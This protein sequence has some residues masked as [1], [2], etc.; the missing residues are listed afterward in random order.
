MTASS[1]DLDPRTRECLKMLGLE[2]DFTPDQLRRR[3][4]RG[5]RKLSPDKGG[6]P[7]LFNKLQ[8]AYTFLRV[9]AR[10]DEIDLN[11]PL[12][13]R[14]APTTLTAVPSQGRRYKTANDAYAA[15]YGSDGC[16]LRGHGDWLK[17]DVP[18][19]Q[20]PPDRVSESRLN[21][22]FEVLN[23]SLGRGPQA[24]STH[25]VQPMVAH[26]TVGYDLND[27]GED[28]TVGHLAD[29]QRAFAGSL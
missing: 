27:S 23:R 9:H 11:Q 25:V 14:P 3:Y 24:L 21:D 7:K 4:L 22:T 1:L 6:D 8:E 16:T 29:L 5:C 26:S 19:E 2:Q 28:Y 12:P 20:R 17:G 10:R 15:M 13:P 18:L